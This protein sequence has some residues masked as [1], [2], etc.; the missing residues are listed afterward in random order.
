VGGFGEGPNLGAAGTFGHLGDQPAGSR[1]QEASSRQAAASL[2]PAATGSPSTHLL[3]GLERRLLR[4][5]AAAAHNHSHAVAGQDFLP[6]E[7]AAHAR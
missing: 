1:Q 2:E 7:A 6:A 3:L 5:P 4:A